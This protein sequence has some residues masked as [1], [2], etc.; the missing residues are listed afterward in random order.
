MSALRYLDYAASA[1]LDPR[2]VRAVAAVAERHGNPSSIHG[3]GRILRAAVDD[4]RG[5]VARLLRVPPSAVT[6]TSGATEANGLALAGFLRP[7]AAKFPGRR[8][9]ALTSPLE[10]ASVRETLDALESSGVV[11]VDVLPSRAGGTVSADDVAAALTPD[12]VM[13]SVM[14][15]N[16]VLGTVQP[17][18]AIGRAVAACRAARSASEPPLVFH[19]DAVQALPTLPAFPAEAGVDLM[20]VSAHKMCGP[21]GAGAL[22]RVSGAALSPLTV[23]GGQ[24][25]GLRHGTENVPGIVGFGVAAEIL[26]EERGKDAE[27]AAALRALLRR[28]LAARM[29]RAEFVGDDGPT[30]IAFIRVPEVPGDRLALALDAAGIAV[31]AGSACDSGK[32]RHPR[33][34][35]AMLDERR[36]AHGGV[37]ASFGRFTVEDDVRAFVAAL[38]KIAG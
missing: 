28:E 30:G 16:N 4:A 24:E 14:W 3:F 17:V 38:A 8:L 21:K 15:A 32:R 9:R 7:V 25:A 2:V 20:T 23:G 6:F 27:R 18:A 1:P 5:Q 29:P 33:V 19:C 10:H 12:T 13:V 31:S 22:V 36:A 26:A 37:R 11:A 35:A 34:L